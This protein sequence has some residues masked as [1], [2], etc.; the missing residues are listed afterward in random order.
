VATAAILG[1]LIYSPISS[2]LVD[3]FG[4]RTAILIFA[5]L[6]VICLGALAKYFLAKTGVATVADSAKP[7]PASGATMSEA[8][9]SLSFWAL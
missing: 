1:L 7:D 8:M 3:R 5:L 9:G 2:L 6:G 4:K